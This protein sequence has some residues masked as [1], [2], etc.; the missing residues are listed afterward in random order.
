MIVVTMCA[1][2]HLRYLNWLLG[3]IK[4]F[5]P[6]I[7]IV[8]YLVNCTSSELQNIRKSFN[9][10][11]LTIYNTNNVHTCQYLRK[12]RPC[13]KISYHK[14]EAIIKGLSYQQDILWLD[15]DT[16][17]LGD[18]SYFRRIL[19]NN[20]LA[21][22][23][24]PGWNKKKSYFNAGVIGIKYNKNMIEFV[25]YWD[26]LCKKDLSNM[27][28]WHK[29]QHDQGRLILTYRKFE[30]VIR[31]HQ[32]PMKFN[33]DKYFFNTRIIHMRGGA[34]FKNKFKKIYASK[35]SKP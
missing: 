24:R 31:L 34:K 1:S 3:S 23:V 5:E 22:L 8:C 20:D 21:I 18:V 32:L 33:A 29:L 16:F 27:E 2:N 12:G 28:E 4:K 6:E 19:Q 9:M 25:D 11:N 17:L 35:I 10:L 26:N 14:I 13:G 7:Q 15:A 30:K